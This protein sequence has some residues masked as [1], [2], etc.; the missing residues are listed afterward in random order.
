MTDKKKANSGSVKKTVEISSH[1]GVAQKAASREF[2]N[3]TVGLLC[4]RASCRSFSNKKISSKIAD[5][6]FEAGVRSATGGNLQPYSIIKTKS[7]KTIDKI[8]E[9]CDQK[10]L[11]SSPMHL[12]FCIDWRRL[13]R[14]AALDAAPFS[15]NNSFRHFWISFQDTIICA[16][17]ICNAA[18]SLGLGSVYIGTIIDCLPEIKKLFDLPDGVM[19]VVLVA[20]GYPKVKSAPRKKLGPDVIVHDELYRDIEDRKLLSAFDKKYEGQ[21]VQITKENLKKMYDVCKN[22]EGEKFAEKAIKRIKEKGYITPVQRYFGLHYQ[23][24]AMASGNQKLLD[25]IKK[26]GFGWFRDGSKKAPHKLK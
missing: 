6:I 16:Q 26:F 2:A 4:E 18:D 21:K 22:V 3:E 19:P 24:D 1:H 14:W 10:F 17:S 15:A 8:A 20:L 5:T 23:A 11:S 7:R 13:K 9:L 25:T 12:L